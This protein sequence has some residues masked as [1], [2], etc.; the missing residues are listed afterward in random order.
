[1][2]F[3]QAIIDGLRAA[4]PREVL[5]RGS[6]RL[7]GQD[8]LAMVSG[9][10]RSL[11]AG[12]VRPGD[13]I[14][15][16]NGRGP[17]SVIGRLVAF[18]LDCPAIQVLPGLPVEVAAETM[19]ALRATAVLY[20]PDRKEEADRLLAACPV[21]VHRSFDDLLDHPGTRP[22][23]LPATRPEDLSSVTFTNGTTGDRKAVAYS[24]RAEVAH[25][26]AARALFGAWP[27]RLLVW[28]GH[29]L[30]GLMA[31]WTL[32]AAGTALLVDEGEIGREWEVI[33]RE[34]ATHVL[35]G[36]P[37]PFYTFTRRIPDEP[38]S[39]PLLLYGGAAAVPARTWEAARR[40]GPALMQ[41]Y[42]LSEAGF[43]T[44]LPPADHA[45]PGLLTSVG[46]AVPGVELQVRDSASVPVS[47]PAGEVGEVWVRSPQVM[48]G[49]VNDP[50]RTAET[51]RG[52]WVRTGDLGRLDGGYLFLV[53]RVE[54]GLPPG[55]H[56][57]PIE[58][59]LTGHP[60]VTDAAVIA[61]RG[62]DGR[63]VTAAVVQVNGPDTSDPGA[64][65]PD[66]PSPRVGAVDARE[67]CDLVRSS[68]GPAS[69]PGHLWVVDDLPRT[70]A[71]KPDKAA[72]L[73][74]F[75][76]LVDQHAKGTA[77]VGPA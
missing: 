21:P 61:L 56:A 15:F 43:V 47:V 54:S 64:S 68:L 10:A 1:M 14:A 66:T 27:W 51:L 72:L 11:E 5:V 29:H 39:V 19:R 3:G 73:A 74:R 26:D 48:T 13:A 24:H 25:L 67:L 40:L 38:G 20:E 6:R 37:F 18:A 63:A 76:P 77:A 35:A 44:A 52:G 70:S 46:R 59:A 2:S 32:A 17:E 49:Y 23:T 30:P 33:A 75:Q 12:G 50:R 55:V 9:A 42:G 58:H 60:S 53:D 57:Y 45:N 71:G 16:L 69:E 65:G 8:V 22:V 7:T 4:G 34:R 41:T 28:P 36:P 31:Q 62:P